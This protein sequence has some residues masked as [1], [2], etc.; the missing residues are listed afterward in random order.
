MI[1]LNAELHP[2]SNRAQVNLAEAYAAV[3]ND[4]AAIEVYTRYVEQH[5]DDARARSRLEGLRNR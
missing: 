2:E 4:A 3:G 5:P 1:E